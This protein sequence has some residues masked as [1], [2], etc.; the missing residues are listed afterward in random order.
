MEVVSE[1]RAEG[2]HLLC[3]IVKINGVRYVSIKRHGCPHI[4]NVPM[5]LLD[6]DKPVI[7]IEPDNSS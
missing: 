7:E 1:L 3:Q 4:Y 6:E 5:R 2:K